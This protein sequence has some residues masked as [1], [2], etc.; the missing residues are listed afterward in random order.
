[1]TDRA[2]PEP[3]PG[4]DVRRHAPATLR[5]REPI[6]DVLRAVLPKQGRVLEVAS[7]SGEHAV[8][9]AR[10]LPGLD[11]QPS[12]PDRD[13]CASIAAWRE[14]EPCPNLH[15][16]FELDAASPADWPV[17]KAEALVCINMV[18]I[19][20]WEATLGLFAGAQRVLEEGAPVVLYGPYRRGDR[21]LEPSNA[22]FDLDLKRRDPRWGLREVEAVRAEALARGFVLE[23]EV[24][25]PANNLCLVFRKQLKPD[26]A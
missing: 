10:A 3:R 7:G 24:E 5:N 13:A 26:P 18:H 16:P 19:S 15:A 21:V 12:D 22:A 17:A 1:M 25:M 8:H 9:F 11:W 4:V 20:P 23:R 6:L 14:A 2:P